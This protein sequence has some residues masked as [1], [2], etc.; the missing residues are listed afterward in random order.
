MLWFFFVCQIARPTYQAPT[1]NG[2]LHARCGKDWRFSGVEFMQDISLVPAHKGQLYKDWYECRILCLGDYSI[3]NSFCSTSKPKFHDYEILSIF[4]AMSFP[5]LYPVT[6]HTPQELR[7]Q[8]TWPTLCTPT[9]F[10]GILDVLEVDEGEPSGAPR[11][12]V[13]HD[14]NVCNGPILGENLSQISFCS[15]QTQ[16]KHSETT[17]WIRICLKERTQIL[18]STWVYLQCNVFLK[19]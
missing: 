18:K 1:Q 3:P 4:Q 5:W 15:V 2:R 19:L 10:L 9:Y 16:P 6:E 11:L 7:A 14:G 12:L 17:V 13:V 8:Q